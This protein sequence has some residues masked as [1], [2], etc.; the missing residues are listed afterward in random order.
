ML[1]VSATQRCIQHMEPTQTDT[2]LA[3]VLIGKIIGITPIVGEDLEAIMLHYSGGKTVCI[4]HGVDGLL[5]DLEGVG[6]A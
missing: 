5:I 2:T 3:E 4:A 1:T 6:H